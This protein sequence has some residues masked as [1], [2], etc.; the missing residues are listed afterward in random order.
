M[1]S[2]GAELRLRSWPARWHPGR[3]LGP[4]CPRATTRPRGRGENPASDRRHGPL[5]LPAPPRHPRGR[6]LG[7]RSGPATTAVPLPR[8]QPRSLPSSRHRVVSRAS[9][10][11]VLAS[12]IA[13]TKAASSSS[14]VPGSRKRWAASSSPSARVRCSRSRSS[15]V[16]WR[17]ST[18][19]SSL[20]VRRGC[21][22][23]ACDVLRPT[24][25][26]PS[27]TRRRELGD[28]LV[29]LAQGAPYVCFEKPAPVVVLDP[30]GVPQRLFHSVA[31]VVEPRPNNPRESSYWSIDHL[32]KR[33]LH[34]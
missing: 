10:T 32:P 6:A 16:P 23:I 9:P 20:S 22:I 28:L 1:R 30:P 29:Y 2:R 8:R 13:L 11:N 31:H 19:Q 14:H 12:A 7:S 5:A 33:R 3:G 34:S 25:P 24:A 15:V 21:A 27:R 26:L 4:P 18:C 17:C